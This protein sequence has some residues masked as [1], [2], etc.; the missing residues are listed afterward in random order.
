MKSSHRLIPFL[1][2]LLNYSAN[3]QLRRLSFLI[4]AAWD[5]RYRASGRPH[6][7]HRFLYCCILIHCCIDVFSAPLHSNERCADHIKHRYS[8]VARVRF[9]G[10]LHPEPLPSSELFWL[11]GVMSQYVQVHCNCFHDYSLSDIIRKHIC[12]MQIMRRFN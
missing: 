8:V 9:R 2:F 10:N 6:R 12:L 4:L 1:P 3:C 7:K 5:S 11:S